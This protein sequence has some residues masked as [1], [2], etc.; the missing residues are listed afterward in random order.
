MD[1]TPNSAR[2]SPSRLVA[3]LTTVLATAVLGLVAFAQDFPMAAGNPN[4]TGLPADVVGGRDAWEYNQPGRAFLRWWDP[5][6]AIRSTVDNDSPG[7]SVGTGIWESALNAQTLAFGYVQNTVGTVPY[8]YVQTARGTSSTDPTAGATATY[9]WQFSNL[10]QGVDHE[11][12]VNLPVGP[13]VRGGVSR[14][15]QRY[16]VYRVTGADGG[17]FTDVVDFTIGAGGYIRIGNGG[18]STDRTFRPTGTTLLVTLYNTVPL[19]VDGQPRD[20]SAR[21]GEE[22]V[23]ADAA[24]VVSQSRRGSST[25]TATP[26]VSRIGATRPNGATETFRWRVVSPA[27]ESTFVGDLS[28]QYRLGVTTS[29][30]HNGFQA[31]PGN[32]FRR[33]LVWSFPVKRP[34]NTSEAEVTAYATGRRDWILGLD[35][36]PDQSL[37][38]ADQRVQVDDLNGGVAPTAGFLPQTDRPTALGPSYFR[39]GVTVG[40]FTEQVL[41]GPSLPEGSYFVEVYLPGDANLP[42]AL[43]VQVLRG[44]TVDGTYTLDQTRPA[45]WYR[46]PFQPRDGTPNDPL[47]AP[48]RVAITNGSTDATD[49]GKIA[50]ADAVRFVR[51]ADLGV[52]STPVQVT[53]QVRVNNALVERSVVIVA[54]ENGRLYCMDAHGDPANGGRP[55]V[56]WTYPSERPASDPNRAPDQDGKDGIAEAPTGF[57]VSSALV[58]R[59]NGTDL[60]YI[61]GQ[62]GKVYCLDVAGRGD[63]TTVRRWTYPDDY[64][65]TT[66]TVPMQAGLRPIA[67][68]VAFGTAAGNR[69]IVIVPQAE[70]RVTALD[71][72][73]DSATKTT[74][75]VWQWPLATD[76]VLGPVNVTPVVAFGRVF[77][78]ATQDQTSAVGEVFALNEADG[79]LAWRQPDTANGG[80]QSFGRAGGVAVPASMLVDPPG[81]FNGGVYGVDSVFFCDQNGKF[82]SLDPANGT[83]RW[84][85]VDESPAPAASLR[86]TYLRLRDATGAG[87]FSNVPV[88]LVPAINGRISAFEAGGAT[89]RDNRH[90]LWRVNLAGSDQVASIAAG[91]FDNPGADPR[92]S[93]M[94]TGDSTGSLY[95]FNSISDTDPQ[96]LTPGDP[97]IDPPIDQGEDETDQINQILNRDD[98]VLLSPEAYDRLRERADTGQISTG[99]ITQART[100]EAQRRHFE[101]G[102]TFY[103]LVANLPIL[104]G[105]LANYYLE[106]E[107]T[108]TGRTS[109]RRQIPVR[110]LSDNPSRGFCLTGVPIMTTGNAG[111]TPGAGFVRV[112]AVAPGQRG[113]RSDQVRLRQPATFTPNPDCDFYTANPLAVRMLRNDGTVDLSIGDGDILPVNENETSQEFKRFFVNGNE[114]VDQWAAN[115]TFVEPAGF[116][117]PDFTSKGEFVAHGGTGKQNVIVIDRSLMVLILGR[118]LTQVRVGPRDIAWRPDGSQTG[119][120]AKPLRAN[121]AGFEDYPTQIPNR[122]LD[123]PD[124][125]RENMGVAASSA[126]SAQNPLFATGVELNPPRISDPNGVALY[127]TRTGFDAQLRRDLTPTVFD[128]TL[129]V[130]RFQPPSPRDGYYGSQ[131]V[132]L[133]T[134]VGSGQVNEGSQVFR[135]YGLGLRVAADERITM[136]T[137]TI[138]L[139]SVPGG[140]GFNGGQ[141]FGPRAPW[142]PN[143]AFTPWDPTS[144]DNPFG[145]LFQP[146]A[147]VNEGNVN[148][149]NVR[150][151]KF[152]ADQFGARPVEIFSPGQHELSWLDAASHLHTSLDFRYAASRRVGSG[153]PGGDQFGSNMVQKARPGDVIGTRFN[154]N[155]RSRP[156]ANLRTPGGFVYDQTLVRPGDPR[157]SLTAPIGTPSGS[158]QRRL[159]V[160]EDSGVPTL[161]GAQEPTLDPAESFSQPGA[162]LKVNVRETRLT[163]AASSK[164][165]PIADRLLNGN[166]SYAWGNVQPTG[167]RDGL[168]NLF[169]AWSSNRLGSSG[170]PDWAARARTDADLGRQDRWRIFVGGLR[171]NLTDEAARRAESP[172]RDLNTWVPE[173]DDRWMRHG[174]V[175]PPG[176]GSWNPNS[177]FTLQQGE[178][179]V[180]GTDRYGS[181]AFPSAG[182]FNMLDEP[183]QQGR[184]WGN[185]RPRYMAFVGEAEKRDAAGNQT[186]VS[187]VMIAPMRFGNDGQVGYTASELSASPLDVT[188]RKSRPSIVQ[189]SNG[190]TEVA[191]VYVTSTSSALGQLFWTNFDPSRGPDDQWRTGNLRLGNAFESLG[192]PSATLRRFRND[193]GNARVELTFSA[194]V[195]GRRYAEVYM[196]RVPVDARTGAPRGRTGPLFYPVRQEELTVDAA[197]G[198]FWAP[199]LQWQTS[200]AGLAN[201]DVLTYDRNGVL[202]SI[203]NDPAQPPTFDSGSGI[204]RFA[205]WLGGD[206]TLDTANGSVRF[207][208]AI[209]RR[210]AK[211]FIRYEPSILRVSS[212]TGANYRSVASLFDDR[213]LGLRWFP[214]NSQRNL[215]GDLS[216]WGNELGQRPP[217]DAP[218]RW[219]RF[220]VA[221]TRTSGEGSAATRPFYRTLRFGVQLPFPVAVRPDGSVIDFTVTFSGGAERFYQIDPASGRVY[222]QSDQEERDVTVRYAAVD[223]AGVSVGTVEWRDR[224]RLVPEF[225]EQAIPME[226][227]GNESGLTLGIDPLNGPFN[228]TTSNG[229]RPG[230]VWLFWGSSRAGAPDVYLQTIA[231]RFSSRPPLQ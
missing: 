115:P 7:G 87:P 172:I 196:T 164:A 203:K 229:R 173:N 154:V 103:I 169:V 209:L 21:P 178:T 230:L 40:P 99:D 15:P 82:V 109:Q 81:Q 60:L 217:L 84:R 68:S 17:D 56:Y 89:G 147:V 222:F 120:V 88:V 214:N 24:Q 67:G 4:R 73:G 1:W 6:Q 145:D 182:F 112:S 157:V 200:D 64:N 49:A 174:A 98:I 57:N 198:V 211:L 223:Q 11:L 177:V 129:V 22:L 155:P 14:F 95:A 181:P 85:V 167:M 55:T 218:I 186:T 166:E 44:A 104:T 96:P 199:G 231:P 42:R 12:Y 184:L 146:F 160:F 215:V 8:R 74:S 189:V 137:P 139:G 16:W 126:G 195:R 114:N 136:A 102:E 38:R 127:R 26:V 161:I 135:R 188:G 228:N 113:L 43:Q 105:N 37:S 71:A 152:F 90:G 121:F 59:V 94:Y 52:D 165:A 72:S 39:G 206:V 28:R 159:Y 156:N 227:V 53:A 20:P 185:S 62:N 142:D 133:E 134:Q 213:F 27:N 202:R 220:V 91:G 45:G 5:I 130:P 13:T 2:K 225:D 10:E 124:V 106:F 191:T 226:E 83:V 61:A 123:Y 107:V 140:G 77:F 150:V 97:P 205:T 69:P 63:G 208:G 18:L 119:G 29:F 210:G 110:P 76:P 3:A 153:S 138:D 125:G 35:L 48:L 171:G 30:V 151:A 194:R 92:H 36:A 180:P 118:G 58:Q 41:Y 93:W 162:M 23:Y 131:L 221:Y 168:G 176:D 141:N 70:G 163:N 101:F 111:V 47:A 207:S 187:Q 190:S 193:P 9:R 79:T 33:N 179:I 100:E 66:P 144:G 54:M 170:A 117:G 192:A 65:P 31:E 143:S 219:D 224:V 75:V 204:A 158:Y 19:D 149:T 25:I 116:F 128:T 108:S 148:L 32:V 34:F 201:L 78:A 80:F 122:S 216:Y 183:T 86:F 212:G 46:L 50:Y 51:Q 175:V 197:S 132:F